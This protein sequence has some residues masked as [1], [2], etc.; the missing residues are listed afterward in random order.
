VA[1]LTG[2]P[3]V[4]GLTT[5]VSQVATPVLSTVLG[6]TQNL[7][8]TTGLG[9][10]VNSLLGTVGGVVNHGELPSPAP[11]FP[12]LLRWAVWSRASARPWPAWAAW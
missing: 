12:L 2:N 1:K 7:V 8:Q 9:Q 3:L 4:S 11:G 6:T 10:P 5:Q